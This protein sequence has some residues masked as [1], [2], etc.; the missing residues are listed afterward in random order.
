VRTLLEYPDVVKRLVVVG[1]SYEPWSA[2]ML[3]ASEK[4]DR[5]ARSYAKGEYAGYEIESFGWTGT[6]L[7]E[8]K[9]DALVVQVLD[10]VPWPPGRVIHT[11]THSRHAVVWLARPKNAVRRDYDEVFGSLQVNSGDKRVLLGVTAQRIIDL[12]RPVSS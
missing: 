6:D 7:K 8:L 4:G 9:T 12:H 1:L 11:E 2:S 10:G 3:R 5:T